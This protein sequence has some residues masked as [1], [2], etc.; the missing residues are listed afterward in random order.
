MVNLRTYRTNYTTMI[1]YY[2]AEYISVIFFF[3]YITVVQGQMQLLAA[4]V[5]V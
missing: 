4:V 3:A 2:I 1:Y 5:N